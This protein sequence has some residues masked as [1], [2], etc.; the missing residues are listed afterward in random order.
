MPGSGPDVELVWV[1]LAEYS[2]KP[3]G[4]ERKFAALLLFLG[5][6]PSEAGTAPQAV[7]RIVSELDPFWHVTGYSD[8]LGPPKAIPCDERKRFADALGTLS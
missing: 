1:S 3:K 6:T 5:E 8:F 4:S 7:T 2:H